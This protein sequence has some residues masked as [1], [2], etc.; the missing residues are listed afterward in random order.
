MANNVESTQLLVL[1]KVTA[2]AASAAGRAFT[3]GGPGAY[4][5]PGSAITASDDVPL[6]PSVRFWEVTSIASGAVVEIG[7]L[8][9]DGE[10]PRTL[11]Y[12]AVV[13]GQLIRCRTYYLR[14]NTTATLIAYY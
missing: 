10:T 6:S 3:D 11:S 4:A 5:K 14:T 13:V 1:E 2:S 8:D 7:V 12:P 9:P